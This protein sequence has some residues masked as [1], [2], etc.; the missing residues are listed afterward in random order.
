M[1]WHDWQFWFVTAAAALAAWWVLRTII[2]PSRPSP[3]RQKRAKLT[4]EG[5]PT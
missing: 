3:K 2:R 4:I 5:R 1:P